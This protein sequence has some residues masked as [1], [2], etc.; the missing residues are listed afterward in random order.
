MLPQLETCLKVLEDAH[1]WAGEALEGLPPE[2]LNWRPTKGEVGLEDADPDA[3]NSLA[4]LV[5]HIRGSERYLIGQ[6]A[7]GRSFDRDR[8]GEFRASG[9]SVET[10]REVLLQANAYAR[11]VMDALTAEQLDETILGPV[12]KVPRRWALVRA[13]AHAGLHAGHMQLT[14]QLWLAHQ[15]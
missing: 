8:P 9:E 12:G 2:A 13:C 15:G 6:L 1:G 4:G 3:T 10:L 5:T 11:E 14:R 7:G